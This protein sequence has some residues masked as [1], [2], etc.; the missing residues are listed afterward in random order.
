MDEL[1]YE[2]LELYRQKEAIRNRMLDLEDVGWISI[3]DLKDEEDGPDLDALQ[4]LAPTLREMA[5]SNPWHIRGSQLRH[6]Y[7]FGRGVQFT[8]VD[9]PA[10]QKALSNPHNKN[11]LFSVDA[12]QTA[13]LALFTDGNY[14]VVRTGDRARAKFT[15]VPLRQIKG[16]VTNPDDAADVWFIKRAW[17]SNDENHERWYPVSRHK[18]T[19]EKKLPKTIAKTPVAQDAV[20]YYRTSNRQS[21]WTWGIP[22]SMGAMVWTQGYSE[23]LKDNLVLVK[24]LSKIAWKITSASSKAATNAGVQVRNSGGDTGMT[25]SMAAGNQL[26]G[27]GVPSAQVNMG[28]GQPIIAAVATSFGVPVIALLASPGETGGSY[29]SA[30]TLTDP[31]L[32]V[33]QGIQNAWS[34]FYEEI[35]QDLGASDAKMEFPAIEIDPIYR[36]ISSISLSTQTGLLHRDEGRRAVM[37]ILDVDKLHDDRNP[38]GSTSSPLCR[39]QTTG[40]RREMTLLLDRAIRG[41]FLAA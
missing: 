20:I 6:A 33:M 30:A 1:D 11:A 29:G 38:M 18:K 41:S 25:A 10:V 15:V 4:K 21:G 14:F 9:K 16:V 35:L 27:V 39:T 32:K 28:N 22:D 34:D 26:Q 13:N 3:T 7:V 37:D 2:E 8:D 5:A 19:S 36:Q 12:Y 40:A 23:Y 17:S 24:A 31:T